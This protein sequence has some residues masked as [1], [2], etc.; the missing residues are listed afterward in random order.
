MNSSQ[1]SA[2]GQHDGHALSVE[3]IIAAPAE[4]IFDG[5]HGTSSW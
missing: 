1:R 2:A 5:H 3:R 4:T